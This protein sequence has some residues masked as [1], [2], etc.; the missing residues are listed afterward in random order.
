M[1][2]F[3][4]LLVSGL[5][6]GAIYSLVAT[7]LTLTYS[8]TGI[9]NLSFGGV[10]FVSA[11][12][13]FVLHTGLGWNS[14]LAAA[15]LVFGFSPLLSIAL[16]WA[17]FRRLAQAPDAAK[18]V[19]TAGLLLA[20]PAL[21]HFVL[22]SI[23]IGLFHAN[24]P[25]GEYVFGIS[26][27]GWTT[28][29]YFHPLF[30]TLTI[31]SNQIVVLAAAAA[32][33]IGLWVLLQR[34]RLGLDMRAV[35]DRPDLAGSRAINAGRTSTW[36]WIVG[37]MLA[38]VAGIVAAPVLSSLDSNSY[39]MLV[40]FATAAAV[41]GRLRSIPMAFFGGL[42]VGVVQ[43]L[44]VGYV[45]FAKDVDGLN[46]SVPFVVLLAGLLMFGRSRGKV[47]GVAQIGGAPTN[48]GADLSV[49]R[50]AIPWAVAVAVL[51][52]Y[53]F[54]FANVYW[55]NV[56]LSGLIVSLILLSFVVITGLGG[57]V[58]L[59]QATFVSVGGLPGGVMLDQ[60][61]WPFLA[62]L[63][64]GV[65]AAVAL[66]LV[67]ALPSLHLGGI[68]F[69]LASLAL[70]FLADQLL[71][72][73]HWLSNGVSGWTYPHPRVGPL[74]LSSPRALAITVLVLIG[75][76][77]WLIHNLQRSSTGRAIAAV[78]STEV[79][80]VSAG[81]AT[82]R[83]KLL[84]VAFGAAIAGLGGVLAASANQ[85]ITNGSF[86]AMT[87]VLWLAAIT[88]FGV[89][90]PGGAVVAGL[91]STIFPALLSG[92]FHWPSWVPTFLNW[93][94]TSDVWIPSILFGLGAVQMARE[95]DGIVARWSR[96]AFVRRL[97]NAETG[98]RDDA[99]AEAEKE[100]VT[101]T[102]DEVDRHARAF[103]SADVALDAPPP[104][105]V[106]VGTKVV[107]G[108]GET[109]V[110]HGVDVELHLGLVTVLV[111]ANGAGK[112]TLCAALAGTIPLRSGSVSFGDRDVSEDPVHRRARQ[113][114]VLIPESRGIFPGLTVEE[115]LTVWLRDHAARAEAFAAFP[116]LRARR[117]NQA[118]DLSG[119]EQQLLALAPLLVRPPQVVI[120]DEPRLGLAPR[121]A[122]EVAAYIA[123]LR[124]AGAAVLLAEE[125]ARDAI[126][127]ADTVVVLE[128]GY[129]VWSGPA[130]QFDT[131]QLADR[132]IGT[133]VGRAVTDSPVAPVLTHQ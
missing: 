13:Y 130:T 35:V 86:P 5:V 62:A 118:G 108:Y 18:L 75:G 76:V 106:V 84:L 68:W 24:V 127:L 81:V 92:G 115:N 73:Q 77:T 21:A 70:A 132:Y 110:L 100:E 9:F 26:G 64:V 25:N 43:N 22:E 125:K 36:A 90:R 28:V 34:T 55:S 30:S 10:A 39:T 56:L 99:L 71:F 133:A 117:K 33:A 41:W 123:A 131:E 119:G 126:E 58:S 50:R 97:R 15:V 120:I 72:Q 63:V 40:V 129:S 6:S 19:A 88:L 46:S 31:T 96:N 128:L 32:V 94:G 103:S 2:T 57:L 48:Y 60:F 101:E 121:A 79:A 116:I 98:T 49:V 7:G 111:G 112:S 59:A 54:A 29:R 53:L 42:A 67:V 87:G 52:V 4:V 23:V 20:L 109:L 45:P 122:Q 78:R 89:R 3:F 16:E 66:G 74:T 83:T 104:R 65:A 38:S 80:A 44:F 11:L 8:A 124:N 82:V 27:L 107:A 69:A 93:K 51:L 114:I 61:H 12:L 14:F 105:P 102:R 1:Q 91:V 113:G 37:T 95:P 85:A 17:V 47:A